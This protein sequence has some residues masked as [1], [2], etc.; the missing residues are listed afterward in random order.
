MSL[1]WI[2]C[3]KCSAKHCL[4]AGNAQATC[5]ALRTL[6][7][8]SALKRLQHAS[9]R[10]CWLSRQD[11]RCLYSTGQSL[12][13]QCKRQS[14]H[15]EL[16]EQEIHH[17]SE[18]SK[19]LS[20]KKR[21]SPSPHSP[22][23]VLDYGIPHGHFPSFEHV[24]SWESNNT[25][26]PHRDR[27]RRGHQT[28]SDTIL[29]ALEPGEIDPLPDN[30]MSSGTTKSPPAACGIN[31]LSPEDCYTPSEAIFYS[32][33]SFSRMYKRF[34]DFPNKID[35]SLPNVSTSTGYGGQYAKPTPGT[36]SGK[37]SSGSFF[38]TIRLS[39]QRLL[40]EYLRSCW[41]TTTGF[42]N[43]DIGPYDISPSQDALQ[44]VFSE[45]NIAFMNNKGY[46]PED[47]VS[48]AWIATA[49]ST[50]R[51][52]RRLI[53]LSADLRFGSNQ[54]RMMPTFVFLLVLRRSDWSAR[55][56]R[57][58]ITHGW[59]RLEG[60]VVAQGQQLDAAQDFSKTRV[61]SL[62]PR[63][64][65]QRFMSKNN[66]VIMVIRLLRL[67]RNVW[68][69]ACVSIA[70]MLTKHER[71]SWDTS[72]SRSKIAELSYLY[73]TILSL[74]ALPSSRYPFLSIS[75][76]QQAQFVV[77]RRMNEFQPHLVIDR[78]GYR[79]VIRVQ[80][81]HKKTLQERDWASL[82]AKS[83]PPWRQDKLG[84]DAEKGLQYGQ[85]RASQAIN[86][87]EEAGYALQE[88]ESSAEILAGWDTDNTPTIQ[89][90]IMH[91][92]PIMSR[93]EKDEEVTLRQTT[94]LLEWVARIQATRTIDEA[95]SCFLAFKDSANR[96][97]IPSKSPKVYDAL[98][99][100]IVFDQKRRLKATKQGQLQKIGL[101]PEEIT[102]LPGDGREVFEPPGPQEAINLRSSAPKIDRFVDM[103]L[104]D[105]V[106]P[107]ARGLTFLLFYARSFK[108]GIYY[109]LHSHIP[110]ALLRNLLIGDPTSTAC[111]I[112]HDIMP[113]HLFGAF[114]HHLSR[115]GHKTNYKGLTD[116]PKW[117]PGIPLPPINP[118]AQACK[119][120]SAYKPY[121]RPPWNS[122]LRALAGKR[123]SLDIYSPY[124]KVK[125]QDILAWKAIL[126]TVDDMQ[127]IGLGLDLSGFRYVC[128]GYEKAIKAS[129]ELI[130]AADFIY[131]CKDLDCDVETFIHN[132][133]AY[134][135][136]LFN[137]IVFG[138]PS[139]QVSDRS[140]VG[141]PVADYLI[142]RLL[143]TPSPV[144]IHPFI[145]ILGLR[146][147]HAGLVELVEW[148]AEFAPEIQIRA[149]EA[150]NGKRMLRKCLTAAVIFLEQS[151][152]PP[153]ERMPYDEECNNGTA[154]E[155]GKDAGRT[156]HCESID[157]TK[158]G[159][160]AQRFRRVIAENPDWGGWPS[161]DEIDMYM[162]NRE[163]TTGEMSN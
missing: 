82:K 13:N 67:A 20:E 6:V 43:T 162:S 155:S 70:T 26:Y 19:A 91:P 7:P 84:L 32:L 68:P 33:G 39:L 40:A 31:S 163:Q 35:L 51:A 16:Q 42:G 92:R 125:I 94:K 118:L 152:L 59:D 110:I 120:M 129:A 141:I 57:M 107:S 46:L 41:P 28:I 74:L 27:T 158:N 128:I 14:P 77:I 65:A 29:D 157:S 1:L 55:A 161:D 62:R 149:S 115:W 37:E 76:Q 60:Y 96:D 89:R 30:F 126:R 132:G 87:S 138:G 36:N 159:T 119:L 47:L 100:K 5:Q 23:I 101:Q 154:E 103:M 150:M 102:R 11:R 3:Q 45:E 123:V 73:N 21:R 131:V 108:I 144:Y 69:E 98:T 112:H 105:R 78:E 88:W 17:A 15:A 81:V 136:D 127:M 130:D 25:V 50:D 80:L 38:P 111:P 137:G 10:S 143:E 142:P 134:V 133:L 122:L 83:W 147:D 56:L 160:L 64:I 86:H 8:P 97:G 99:E 121:Y 2:L 117:F 145:R 34:R 49:D 72:L 104:Q 52:V 79:A 18:T 85:S 124:A 71:N 95:W 140:D 151:W 48:W 44:N 114:I 93:G 116:I 58:M 54:S 153:E 53:A 22:H 12:L 66:T 4:L 106:L 109:L 113:N 148:M 24:A 139:F 75:A 146:E 9:Q 135:K 63:G 61:Q 156:I 90:R